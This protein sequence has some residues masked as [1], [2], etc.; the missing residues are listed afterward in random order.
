MERLIHESTTYMP[1]VD[2]SPK[3]KLEIEGRAIPEDANKFFN[4]LINFVDKLEAKDVV[5][6]INLE[7]FNTAASKE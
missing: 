4:P 5:M 1:R 3:G 2:F 7:Y 6:D